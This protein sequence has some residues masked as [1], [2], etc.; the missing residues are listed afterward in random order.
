MGILNHP[1]RKFLRLENCMRPNRFA[2]AIPQSCLAFCQALIKSSNFI[3][4]IWSRRRWAHE[5]ERMPLK[6]IGISLHLEVNSSPELNSGRRSLKCPNPSILHVESQVRFL[7]HQNQNSMASLRLDSPIS[8]SSWFET[9]D[10]M[11]CF[12]IFEITWF[13]RTPN[14]DVPSVWVFD[15]KL[16]RKKDRMQIKKIQDSGQGKN[17]GEKRNWLTRNKLL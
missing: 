2:N 3:A 6:W 8:W 11:A 5:F 17:L 14:C 10:L 1:E 16:P 7:F 15:Q 12:G 13:S 4:I 9:L